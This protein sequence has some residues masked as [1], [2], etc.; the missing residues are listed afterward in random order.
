MEKLYAEYLLWLHGF[1][2][3]ER[4]ET[5]LDACFLNSSEDI[6]LDLEMCSSPMRD[7]RGRFLR[8]WSYECPIFDADTFGKS[9]FAG[10]KT[11]YEAGAFCIE[12][13]GRRCYQLWKD[14][15][16]SLNQTEPFF[17][18]C[19]ADDCLSWGDEAQ[20]RNLY[21]QAFSFYE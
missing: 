19:Y 9:L 4:Y 8:Y 20:T 2:S 3:G 5:L 17:I 16:D 10:L 7:A 12:D 13:F 18:L 6:L 21:E 15:P 11:V 14:I 1:Y